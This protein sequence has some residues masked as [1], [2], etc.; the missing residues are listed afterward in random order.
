[1]ALRPLVDPADNRITSGVAGIDPQ[2]CSIRSLYIDD[3]YSRMPSKQLVAKI[4]RNFDDERV[5]PVIVVVRPAGQLVVIKGAKTALAAH[6]AGRAEI[7]VIIL[8]VRSLAEEAVLVQKYHNDR[9]KLTEVQNH[10]LNLTW[11]EEI[12]LAIEEVLGQFGLTAVPGGLAKGRFIPA[13]AAMRYAW[14][15]EGRQGS[16]V[17]LS[18]AD[19]DRGKKVLAWAIEAM[20]AHVPSTR[21]SLVYRK[22]TLRA[23]IWIARYGVKKPS[24]KK[25]A[26]VL[27]R[28]TLDELARSI[29]GREYG[30]SRAAVWGE[31]LGIEINAATGQSLIVTPSLAN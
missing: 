11:G 20:V 1:M 21:A 16:N 15:H 18:P 7:N 14:G 19:I 24:A 2:P 23:L 30:N 25:M 13:V 10:I 9:Q 27:A 8:P 26:N 5:S 17:V 4:A 22:A 3:T 28:Y 29:L 31:R 6:E 12:A